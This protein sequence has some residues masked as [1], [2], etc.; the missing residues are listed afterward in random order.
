M[1]CVFS[2]S[3]DISNA[4]AK[5]SYLIANEI[6]LASKPFPFGRHQRVPGIGAYARHNHGRGHFQRCGQG[7][8]GLDRCGEFGDRWHAINDREKSRCCGQIQRESTGSKWRT[9]FFDISL[10]F[11]PGGIVLQVVKN[12]SR[13]GSGCPD[14]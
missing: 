10:Y 1:K 11:A 8:G 3:R 2:R 6:A 9:C 12:G 4:A 14:C 13:H 7:R 5:V